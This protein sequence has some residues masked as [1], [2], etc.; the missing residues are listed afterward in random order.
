[1]E[2]NNQVER[3]DQLLYVNTLSKHPPQI[4]KQL[5]ASINN[6]LSNNSSNKHGCDMSK[7]DCEKALRENGYKNV[8]L[9]YT[10]KKNIKQKRN[11]SKQH[12]LVQ[13]KI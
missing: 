12:H 3:N 5:A 7:S 11:D 10:N 8:R 9:I 4:I 2:R 1:M 13:S 6:R